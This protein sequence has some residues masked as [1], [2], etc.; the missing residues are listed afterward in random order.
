[1]EKLNDL[2]LEAEELI[3]KKI[4]KISKKSPLITLKTKGKDEISL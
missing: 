1:M 4:L 3:K 2:D